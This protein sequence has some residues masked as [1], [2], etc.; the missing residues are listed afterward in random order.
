[1]DTHVP[2]IVVIGSTNTDMSGQTK[3]FPFQAK[4]FSAVSFLCFPVGKGLTRL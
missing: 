2:K 4:L 1:M 3:N